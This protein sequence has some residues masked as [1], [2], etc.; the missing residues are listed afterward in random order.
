MPPC[1]TTYQCVLAF[2]G[3]SIASEELNDRLVYRVTVIVLPPV[4]RS[5]ARQVLFTGRVSSP[6]TGGGGVAGVVAL[7]AL[8][9]AD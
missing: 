6:D 5:Q 9:R 8:D 7:A 4:G 2:G 3:C 1:S